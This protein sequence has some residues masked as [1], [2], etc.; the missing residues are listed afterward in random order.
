MYSNGYGVP[1]DRVQATEWYRKAAEQ[2]YAE[3]Q[4]ALGWMYYKRDVM[5]IDHDPESTSLSFY[6][7][8]RA[9]DQGHEGAAL[10]LARMLAEGVGT[11]EDEGEAAKWY[12]KAAELGNPLAQFELGAIYEYGIGVPQDYKQAVY[13]LRKAAEQDYKPAQLQLAETLVEGR[14]VPQDLVMAHLWVNL[15]VVG[16]F[17]DLCTSPPLCTSAQG[18]YKDAV[19]LRDVITENLNPTQLAQAQKLA[20]EW[21]PKEPEPNEPGPT[22]SILRR[23]NDWYDSIRGPSSD[24][25]VVTENNEVVTDVLVQTNAST[26]APATPRQFQPGSVTQVTKAGAPWADISVTKVQTVGKYPGEYFSDTPASGNVYIQVWVTYSALDNGVDYNPFDWALFVDDVAVDS[27]TV[28][29]NG[30]EPKLGSGTLPKGRRAEGWI[31]YEIPVAGRAVM[32]YGGNQ[33]NNEPPLF[34]FLLRSN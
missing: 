27:L 24:N 1:E 16:N 8:K 33:F 23:L 13:W 5:G 15:A 4:F 26:Q 12:R 3:A 30:P 7:R 34:E 6:W 19:R 20:R 22:I 31:V 29:F 18:R 25:Q 28:L 11:N 14:I 2:G 32:S 10:L 21:K 17:I 9:A